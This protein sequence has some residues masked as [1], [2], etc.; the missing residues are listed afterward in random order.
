MCRLILLIKLII[1]NLR[2]DVKKFEHLVSL[3]LTNQN[4]YS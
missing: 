4:K 2:L 3:F 1:M